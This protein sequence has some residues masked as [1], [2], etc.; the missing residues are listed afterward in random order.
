[1]LY[2][3]SYGAL[4]KNKINTC[5][6]EIPPILAII[7]HNPTAV[8]LTTVGYNSAVY[9]YTIE[10]AEAAPNFPEKYHFEFKPTHF[11]NLPLK[12]VALKSVFIIDDLF[13]DTNTTGF[14]SL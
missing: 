12:N 6:A 11:L 9:K 14:E 2:P 10:N 4:P 13:I 1:M 7:E 8:L 5:G 3:L